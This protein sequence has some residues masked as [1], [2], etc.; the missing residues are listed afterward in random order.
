[1]K[2]VLEVLGINFAYSYQKNAYILLLSLI[3]PE[4]EV[5]KKKWSE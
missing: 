1:L 2:K 3:F 4:E 5:S